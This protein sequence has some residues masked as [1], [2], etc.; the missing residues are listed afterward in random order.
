MRLRQNICIYHKKR[1]FSLYALNM[2]PADSVGGSFS[3]YRLL[4]YGDLCIKWKKMNAKRVFSS[5]IVAFLGKIVYLCCQV[6]LCANR[7]AGLSTCVP[8]AGR[9]YDFI[10]KIAFAVIR[11]SK[12]WPQKNLYAKHANVHDLRERYLLRRW[13]WP[14][15]R[16]VDRFRSRFVWCLVR[17]CFY[18]KLR[19]KLKAYASC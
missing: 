16:N 1:L 18:N 6:L 14:S 8:T 5:D 12:A 15:T 9:R 2:A 17:L 13:V 10:G 7:K 3:F 19:I 11:H 4:F